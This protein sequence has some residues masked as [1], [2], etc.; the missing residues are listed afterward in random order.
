MA[1]PCSEVP[2]DLYVEHEGIG[3][4]HVHPG[5]LHMVAIRR[6]DAERNSSRMSTHVLS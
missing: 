3:I 5:G 6:G 1:H 2:S 4:C